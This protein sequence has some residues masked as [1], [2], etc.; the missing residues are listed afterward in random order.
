MQ[1]IKYRSTEASL[2]SAGSR[3]VLPGQM[4]GQRP[5]VLPPTAFLLPPSFGLRRRQAQRCEVEDST[6]EEKG[7]EG[8][9]DEEGVAAAAAAAAAETAAVSRSA[10]TERHE[11]MRGLRTRLWTSMLMLG[12]FSAVVWCG[13]L[14][15]WCLIFALQAAMC[16]ELF[17]LIGRPHPTDRSPPPPFNF[18]NW[19]FFTTAAI[20]VYGGFIDRHLAD[21]ATESGLKGSLQLH[22]LGH[23]MRYHLVICYTLYIIGFV[24]FTLSLKEGQ[25]RAQFGQYG[26][27]HMVLF[28]V[29]LQSSCFVAGIFQGIIWFLLPASLIIVND[30]AAHLFGFFFGRTPLIELSPKKTWEGFLGAAVTTLVAAF[31]LAGLMGSYP[32]LTCPRKDL[33]VGALRCDPGPLFE[34]KDYQLPHWVSPRGPHKVRAMPVQMHALA[35]GAFASTV[36]P[37]GGFF[38]SGVKRAFH[39]KDFGQSIPGHGGITDRMDCQMV[40]ALFAYVYYETFVLRSMPAN[41]ESLLSK[42]TTLGID[43]QQ[44]L[45]VRLG[46]VLRQKGVGLVDLPA[47]RNTSCASGL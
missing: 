45:Y 37:F 39:I 41:V 11:R 46:N 38:A 23:V 10:A 33:G 32:W 15:I 1:S 3:T 18:L 34:P 7:G 28:L 5:Q 16:R 26:W 24:R 30:T 13:H 2:F 42:I 19:H 43:Q 17:A 6:G 21:S 35:F 14:F 29:F 40:M 36:A 4:S 31:L 25:Y 20:F 12:G 27:C 44:E 47:P 8:K 22:A 9:T